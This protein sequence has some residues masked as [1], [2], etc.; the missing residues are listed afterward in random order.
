MDEP[1]ISLDEP[2][3]KRLRTLLLTIWNERPT[4]VLFITHDLNEALFLAD[5]ILFMSP[6]PGRIVHDY[7]VPLER[8]RAKLASDHIHDLRVS[9]LKENPELLTGLMDEVEAGELQ[10]ES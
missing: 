5:R 8:P 3:A 7:T 9:L 2:V 10:K 4:T 1:F 6:S